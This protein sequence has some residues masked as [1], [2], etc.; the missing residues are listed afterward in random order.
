[1]DKNIDRMLEWIDMNRRRAAM[2][3]FAI[4]LAIVLFKLVVFGTV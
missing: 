3:I 2:L 4:G 1:M